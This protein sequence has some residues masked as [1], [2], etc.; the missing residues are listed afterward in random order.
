M[1]WEKRRNNCQYFYAAVRE[2]NRVRKV[3]LGA[4]EAGRRAAETIQAARAVLA[5]AKRARAEKWRAV[6]DLVLDLDEFGA[7]IDR[8]L[9]CEL[10]G[11]GW[12][13]HHRSWRRKRARVTNH[14]SVA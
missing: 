11:N 13:R 6:D 8:L 7:A 4:G 3:Y 1:G 14:R 10:I 9:T 2:G 5:E 12:K